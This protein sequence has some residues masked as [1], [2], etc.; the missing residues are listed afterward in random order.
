MQTDSTEK[1]RLMWARV[2]GKTENALMKLGFKAAYNFRPGG[3]KAMP[4]QQNLK[5]TYKS[6]GWLYP[7]FHLLLP[8]Q[9]STLRDV[10]VAMIKCAMDGYPKSILE[11]K[12]INALART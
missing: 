6:L 4:G 9:V 12:D 10:A 5:W 1:G 11:V 8:N 2:K 3:M 7:V